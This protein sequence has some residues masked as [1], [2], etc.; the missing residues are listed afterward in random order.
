MKVPLLQQSDYLGAGWCVAVV[1]VFDAAVPAGVQHV[2][3]ALFQPDAAVALKAGAAV[4]AVE[5]FVPSALV[6]HD[7][8]EA[9]VAAGLRALPE[10]FAEGHC[11]VAD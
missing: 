9:V 3:A 7:V 11:F 1:V 8:A 10:A 2:S 4:S 5:A 6:A